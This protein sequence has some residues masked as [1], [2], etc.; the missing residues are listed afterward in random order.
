MLLVLVPQGKVII[1][2]VIGIIGTISLKKLI[3]PGFDY[4]L[5]KTSMRDHG[6]QKVLVGLVEKA[7][8]SNS[9]IL[10][11]LLRLPQP[12]LGNHMRD[13]TIT[14]LIDTAELLEAIEVQAVNNCIQ[15]GGIFIL[16]KMIG[17]V[18]ALEEYGGHSMVAHRMN[19]DEGKLYP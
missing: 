11:L 14:A 3:G 5:T 15:I 10:H 4:R 19:Q 7:V 9:S 6:E 18:P 2:A 8:H 17:N 12:R 1:I 13:I 16:M